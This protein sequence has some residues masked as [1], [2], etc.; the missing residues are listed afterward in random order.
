MRLATNQQAAKWAPRV[1]LVL[2]AVALLYPVAW[3][4]VRLLEEARR[5]PTPP[6]SNYANYASM[7]VE[8]RKALLDQTVK[9]IENLAGRRKGMDRVPDDDPLIDRILEAPLLSG[10]LS[11]RLR[12]FRWLHPADP[13][14]VIVFCLKYEQSE[15]ALQTIE[16]Y[17]AWYGSPS[18]LVAVVAPTL[19]A[20]A[21]S[22]KHPPGRRFSDC[23]MYVAREHPEQGVLVYCRLLDLCDGFPDSR[24]LEAL[25]SSIHFSGL[26]DE[27]LLTRLRLTK[28]RHPRNSQVWTSIEHIEKTTA[29]NVPLRRCR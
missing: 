12:L 15:D 3:F 24:Y 26:R 11:A 25:L 10:E 7:D 9:D 2:A 22:L 28:S 17:L 29:E 13:R 16:S 1:L 6:L 21:D 20:H 19:F 23:F 18:E 14:P 27:I 8:E 4:C 5:P